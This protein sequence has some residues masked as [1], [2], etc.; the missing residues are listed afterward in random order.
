MRRSLL[1]PKSETCQDARSIP[2][3]IFRGF[4][5]RHLSQLLEKRLKS[6]KMSALSREGRE[7]GGVLLPFG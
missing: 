3:A 7:A 4:L 1:I 6:Q 5:V 2:V